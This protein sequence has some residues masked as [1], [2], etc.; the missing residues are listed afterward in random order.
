MIFALADCNNFYASCER[1][2]DPKLEGRPIVVL[3]NND[4]CVVARSDEA[5][6]LGIKLGTPEFEIRDLLTAHQVRIFSSNYVLYGDMS[7][8]V[9]ETLQEFT[10][11][12]EVYSIDEAF[13]DFSGFAGRDLTEYARKIRTTVKQWTGLPVSLGVATTKTL[14]KVANRLAK[15]SPT[16]DGVV[17][18]LGVTDLDA[19]LAGIDVADVWG[20][21]RNY[22]KMLKANNIASALD[23]RN[24]DDRWIRRRMGVVGLRTVLELRG[25]SCYPLEHNPPAKQSI[26]VSRS[27]GNPIQTLEEMKQAVAMHVARAG[28][29]L[30]EQKLAAQVMTVFMMTDRFKDPHP[31]YTTTVELPV[32][33]DDTQEMLR[34]AMCCTEQLFSKNRIYK[35]AGIFLMQLTP[36]DQI[37]Q[38]LFYDPD[39]EPSKRLMQA[40]DQINLKMGSGTI[41]FASA[42]VGASQRW[43]VRANHRSRCFTTR[44]NELPIVRA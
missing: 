8:R 28:E 36:A 29:K 27:F 35:K 24:A 12:I 23:L 6:A 17:N 11:K 22:T 7:E 10:P 3:S 16:A 14:A 32:A 19:I 9:M 1:V 38:N 41:Q 43:Q 5:K 4:G 20:I 40:M 21:G 25:T 44:W 31:M 18:F 33:T 2:F 39:R 15:K 30:R 37:Q 13:L 26:G 42:G 34:F